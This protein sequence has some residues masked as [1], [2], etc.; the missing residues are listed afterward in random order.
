MSYSTI[1]IIYNPNSTGSGE[2]LARDLEEQ[3]HTRLPNQK[4]ELIETGHAGHGEELAY[5]IALSSKNPLII[6]SSGDGGYHEVINGIMRAQKKGLKITTGLLPAGNANDHYHNLHTRDIIDQI[7]SNE[8]TKIDL[9]KIVGTSK[10]KR[11]ERYAH[12]Y[13]GFGLTPIVGNELNK[14]KLTPLNEFWIVARSLFA[15]KPI[16]LK[17]GDKTRHYES[18]IFSNVDVMSKYLKISQPSSVTDGKFEVTI[19]KRHNKLKLIM[20][21][22][23]ASVKALKEDEQVSEFSLK[24][25]RNTL[26]QADGEI[27]TLDGHSD[28]SITIEPRVLTCII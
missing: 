16:R 26:V 10:G 27:M 21:L 4:V 22:L 23:Q 11:V 28:V 20:L 2:V 15:I 1:A 25:V 9:L 3:I 6:S 19:F 5:S 13:I 17:I 24:T 12:S 7:V 14:T 8:T 18:I